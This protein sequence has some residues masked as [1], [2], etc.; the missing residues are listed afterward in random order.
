MRNLIHKPKLSRIDLLDQRFYCFTSEN[1]NES[2]FPSVTEILSI[3]PKGH[4]F[5]QWLKDVGNN[6]SGIADRAAEA[7]TKIHGAEIG[8]AHV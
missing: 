1:G 6:A 8:R 4:G 7:G 5:E 2:Y 3:Y